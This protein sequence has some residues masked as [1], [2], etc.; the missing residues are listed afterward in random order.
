MDKYITRYLKA[1]NKA[2]TNR[3]KRVILDKIY[4]DG[5]TDGTNEGRQT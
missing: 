1:V 5:F 4:H 3:E 2:K